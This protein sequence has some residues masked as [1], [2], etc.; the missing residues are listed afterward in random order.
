MH[1]ILLSDRLAKARTLQVS[2]RQI[3]S[4]TAAAAAGVVVLSS[5]ISYFGVRH[6]SDLKLPL[7]HSLVRAAQ[8][9]ESQKTEAYLR[10]NLNVMAIKLGE[11]QAQLVRLD[12][13]G[14]RLSSAAG[15][16]PGEFRFGEI[17]GRG[18]ALTSALPPQDLSLGDLGRQLDFMARQMETRGDLLG[19]L[20]T[21]MLDARV[22]QTLTPTALPVHGTWNASGFGWRIDPITGQVALHE[23][24]DFIAEAGTPIYAAAAGVVV[25]AA[26]HPAYG[27]MVEIDHGADLLTRYA[28]ASK[29][30]ARPGQLVKRGEKI[31]EVGST[32][33]ST[34]SHLHFE[35]RHKGA[36]QNPARFLYAG[37]GANVR[38]A[39][40]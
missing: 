36:A 12:A 30:E 16:R 17:P 29:L 9:E 35:V 3:A 24:I 1:I 28:H 11:M 15:I 21:R 40:K 10:D 27:N 18:G 5:L 25:T 6:A 39:A 7:L 13:L 22:K 37:A 8:L 20:E 33:R 4:A 32:G 38:S 31:A 34:G 14:E 26:Y 23:G 2:L 19:V